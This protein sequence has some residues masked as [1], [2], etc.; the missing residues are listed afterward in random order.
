MTPEQLRSDTL[1]DLDEIEAR[2][3]VWNTMTADQKRRCKAQR[4]FWESA[5]DSTLQRL[6]VFLDKQP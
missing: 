1:A 4:S 6:I 5:D 2:P 3:F